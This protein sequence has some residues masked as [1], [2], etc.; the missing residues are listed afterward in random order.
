MLLQEAADTV[1][2]TLEI[3]P[4]QASLSIFNPNYPR[5]ETDLRNLHRLTLLSVLPAKE[6]FQGS[7][8]SSQGYYQVR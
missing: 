5:L 3:Y 2:E 4:C 6:A 1:F 8:N 7:T